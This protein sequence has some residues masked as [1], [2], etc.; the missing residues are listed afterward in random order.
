MR[1]GKLDLS[2]TNRILRH[3]DKDFTSLH[4]TMI[5]ASEEDQPDAWG[6]APHAFLIEQAPGVVTRTHFHVNSQ[7]QVFING[8]G[9]LGRRD[10]KPFVVQYV[11]PHTGY[12]PIVAGDE[13]I[14]YITLRPSAPSFGALYLPDD[15]DAMDMRVP[16]VNVTSQPIPPG[17]VSTSQPVMSFL[18]PQ[19]DGLAAWM[20]H[21]PAGEVR[22]A[23]LHDGG[24]GR[25]YLVAQGEMIVDG[26]QLAPFSLA[27]QSGAEGLREIRAGGKDLS[28]MILQF[29]GNAH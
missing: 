5:L 27:W 14:W 24:L 19:S 11:G 29:P 7:F 21:V 4:K 1:I 8:A 23:P 26:E 15:R 20:V 16:K 6:L 17:A 3:S 28:V 18:A 13:G 22:P 12:G 25:F 2:P 10:V 9:Q